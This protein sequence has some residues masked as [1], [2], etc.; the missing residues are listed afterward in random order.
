MFWKSSDEVYKRD[1]G[2]PSETYECGCHC[3]YIK[4]AVTLSPP[5]P[6]YEVME[7]HCSVC[8][9][10]GYLLVYPHRKDVKWHGESHE[11]CAVY[12]FNTKQKD[13]LFCPRCGAS[14]GIDF[15]DFNKPRF[16]GP[17]GPPVIQVRTFNGIDLTKL[18]YHYSDGVQN[19]SPAED[20]S[21]QWYKEEE[22]EDKDKQ[23][24]A[25]E[26]KAKTQ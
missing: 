6:E 23:G 14:L 17:S 16:D 19:V 24:K 2:R 10:M 25:V 8:R 5:L 18:K 12:R 9:R 22:D 3:G 4:F 1:P 20:L 26:D 15:R 13:Q 7:C 11:R 21:G